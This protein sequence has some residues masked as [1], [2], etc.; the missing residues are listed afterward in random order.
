MKKIYYLIFIIGSFLFFAT[1][2]EIDNYPEPDAQVFGGIRDVV[3]GGLVETDM[4]SGSTIGVYE[5][6][7]YEA[8]PVRKTWYIKQNGEYR[9]NLV[10]SNKYRFDFSSCN[11]FPFDTTYTINPGG[12]E[13]DF[14]VTPYI[15]IKDV[16]IIHDAVANKIVATFKIE[17]G[18]P[19]VKVSRISLYAWSDIYVGEYVK[20]TLVKGTGEPTRTLTGAAQT[21]NPAT[22]YTLSIDLAANAGTTRDG[23]GIHRNYYFRVGALAIQTGVGTIRPNYAPYVKIAL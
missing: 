23:F 22:E 19:T 15:R 21:I 8:N 1:S 13:I 17:G 5:L 4:N 16:S 3:G 6:G 10:Y 18:A 11:F 12:N 14:I 2:C 20:K 7:Q 9:N